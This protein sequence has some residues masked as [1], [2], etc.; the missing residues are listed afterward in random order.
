VGE[1]AIVA[2][3]AVVAKDVPPWTVVGG[4]PA[5]VIKERKLEITEGE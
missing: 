4:N 2:A 1:G 5:R 3:G